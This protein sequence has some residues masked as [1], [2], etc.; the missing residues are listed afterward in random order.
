MNWGELDYLIIDTP[1]G[2]SD[3][4]ISIVQYLNAADIS[5]A[6]VIT[7]PQEISMA[8]VRKELNFCKKTGVHVLG[9]V[10]NMS[11]LSI[12]LHLLQPS[13]SSSSSSSS[14][15]SLRSSSGDLLS[16][17][18]IQVLLSKC[19]ELLNLTLEVPLFTTGPQ[20][21]ASPA[22]MAAQFNVPYLGRI[23]MDANLMVNNTVY[24]F[25]VAF[26]CFYFE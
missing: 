2:T 21:D 22:K 25:T 10:E 20:S 24:L 1:P 26:D 5:G 6:I 9:V 3:E 14:T 23:P 16:Q 13:S 18:A 17:E 12:P 8:D 7:T 4:H 19:P 11:N 15:V